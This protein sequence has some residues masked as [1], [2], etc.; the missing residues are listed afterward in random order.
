MQ[1]KFAEK[2]ELISESVFSKYPEYAENEEMKD[3]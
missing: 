2:V 1:S 3:F